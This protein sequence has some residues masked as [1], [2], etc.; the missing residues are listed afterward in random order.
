[1]ES[2][3]LQEVT[4]LWTTWRFYFSS[5]WNTCV[6]PHAE[7]SILCS[8]WS[9]LEQTTFGYFAHWGI[10][11]LLQLAMQAGVVWDGGGPA[12]PFAS[13]SSVPS[14]HSPCN[15]TEPRFLCKS[16]QK[17]SWARDTVQTTTSWGVL[18]DLKGERC[19]DKAFTAKWILKSDCKVDLLLIHNLKG[20]ISPS[21][22]YCAAHCASWVLGLGSG[23]RTQSLLCLLKENIW[24]PLLSLY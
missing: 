16:K 17:H 2:G 6:F 3:Q 8:A 20:V 21:C 12:A 19:W 11:A 7:K 10:L 1:M 5:G 14:H 23:S 24:G 4:T 13:P 9:T 15:L 18:R 22:P